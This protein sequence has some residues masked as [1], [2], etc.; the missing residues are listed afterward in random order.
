MGSAAS[1]VAGM[2]S[3]VSGVASAGIGASAPAGQQHPG[4]PTPS[5]AAAAAAADA[6]A[7]NF[8]KLLPL[9]CGFIGDACHLSA[10]ILNAS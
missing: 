5:V 10:A 8:C 7:L 4:A 6:P 3:D 9:F 1:V 2:G